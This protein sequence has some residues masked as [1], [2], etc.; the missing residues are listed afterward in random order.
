MDKL[1]DLLKENPSMQ[2]LEAYQDVLKDMYSKELLN[3]YKPQI[4]DQAKI[5]SDRKWYHEP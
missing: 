5:A 3:F 1:F 4:L 2:R